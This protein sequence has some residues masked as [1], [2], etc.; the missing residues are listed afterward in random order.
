MKEAVFYWPK[1]ADSDEPDWATPDGPQIWLSNIG[2]IDMITDPATGILYIIDLIYKRS[3]RVYNAG[4]AAAPVVVVPDAA[5][6]SPVLYN[7]NMQY[8][9]FG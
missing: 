7:F 8:Y 9:P 1:A 6:V 2:I 3:I 5:S 4:A